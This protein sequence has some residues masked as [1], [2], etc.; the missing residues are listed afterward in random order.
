M[1]HRTL[2]VVM[3]AAAVIG[4]KSS[5]N[6][7][8]VDASAADAAVAD[9]RAVDSRPADAA[10]DVRPVVDAPGNLPAQILPVLQIDLPGFF[11]ETLGEIPVSGILGIIQD[12][13]GTHADLASRPVSFRSRIGLASRRADYGGGL[14]FTLQ[15][16]DDADRPVTSSLLGLP[17]QGDWLLSPCWGDKPCMRNNLA[18]SI[19]AAMGMGGP[20]SQY[21]ELFLNGTYQG[22]YQLVA[23]ARQGQGRIDIPAAPGDTG[24]ELTGGYV[25]RREGIGESIPNGLTLTDWLSPTTAPGMWPNQ[26]IYTYVYPP[27]LKIT[28]PQRDYLTTYAASFE[29]AMKADSWAD[30]NQGYPAWIDVA[31]WQDFAVMAEVSNDIDA[32][33]KNL[34]LT[35]PRDA[36]AARGKLVATPLWDFTIGFGN[37]NARQGWRTDKLAF[38][39]AAA[40]GGECT[41]PE[42]LPR[43]APLCA[44]GCCA[45]PRCLAPNR[46]YN[47]PYVPFYWERL[48]S[49]PAFRDQV[50]CR[51]K[52]LRA[53]GGPL[54][55][56]MI[57]QRIAS[58][59]AQIAPNAYARHLMKNG[60]LA[61]AVAGNPYNIDPRTAPVA[62]ATPAAF[63]DKEIQWFRNWV[64][65]RL[66]WLDGNLPGV[67]A[68]AGET[69]DAGTPPDAGPPPAPDTI[70][71]TRG[72]VG[73]WKFD[74]GTGTMAIDSSPAHNNGT[75]MGIGAMDWTL[76]GYKGGGLVFTPA[77]IPSVVV[78][79][80]PSLNPTAGITLGAWFNSVDWLG[81]RRFIQKGNADN[82][83]RLLEENGLLVF[84]LTGVVNGVLTTFMPPTGAFHHLM[85]TYDG[86]K[87]RI[88]IDG[89]IA[90]EDVALGTI[91]VTNNNVHI[92]TKIPTA[93]AGDA[94]NGLL[95]EVVIYDRALNATEVGKLATGTQPL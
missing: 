75:L 78:L 10:G 16:R 91:A 6:G 74:D 83:Y 18:Y 86:M 32:Y 8:K 64:N 22:L 47:M 41:Q 12:H 39:V 56:A 21:I 66:T 48:Q 40:A 37:A 58:W 61:R 80:S 30:P 4:C 88:Y 29:E 27:P 9:A 95:D 77:K 34:I 26:L 67:C 3:A 68:A 28:A 70:E 69:P 14:S 51:Y 36:G 92:G 25:F 11:I 42:W 81:N 73:Y 2:L 13:D 63:L 94:F 20:R 65:D 62:G 31:S 23:P 59:Q 15:L 45:V 43:A 19:G 33:W 72:L 87:M 71:L 52:A 44:E 50:R 46:C 82:Q 24:A 17:Y 60:A 7:G 54:D 53:A 85:A 84:N 90:A 1:S 79:D 89:K 35:K 76:M 57:D 38:P 5:D 93:P 55:M 49:T